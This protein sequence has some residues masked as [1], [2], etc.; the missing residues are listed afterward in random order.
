MPDGTTVP[1][2]ELVTFLFSKNAGPYLITFDILFKNRRMYEQAR[3]SGALTREAFAKL[4]KVPVERI[5]SRYEYDAADMIK[6]TMVRD[7]S[8]SDFGDRSVFGSQQ[9]APLLDLPVPIDA[10]ALGELANE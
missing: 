3:D 1:L 8:S 7:I 9:W 10:T 5:I 2:K 4:Y 6:F